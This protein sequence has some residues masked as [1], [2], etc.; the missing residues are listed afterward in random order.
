[1]E[2]SA[3]TKPDTDALKR[4]MLDIASEL[5]VPV[6][7]N[8]IVERLA[9]QPHVA[10]ARIWLQMPADICHTCRHRLTCH[11]AAVCLHLSATFGYSI[12]GRQEEWTKPERSP[13]FRLPM[14]QNRVGR[15]AQTKQPLDIPD[16][17]LAEALPQDSFAI[18]KIIRFS[19]QPMLYRGDLVGVLG[20]F[21]RMRP[22]PEMFT[23]LRMI[24]DQAA[25]A[26]ANARAFHEIEEL[27]AQLEQENAYLHE[28]LNEVHEAGEI[29]G[30]SPAI[31]NILRQIELVAPT[32]ASVLILGSRAQ[33]KSWWLG[34]STKE[35]RAGTG[36]WSR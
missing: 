15:I 34:R 23:W 21:T 26:V 16:T 5:S 11:D 33:A 20:V 22:N 10:L 4:L 7:M 36:P 32:E 3:S 2:F 14:G 27:K 24:A 12:A 8:T 13:F 9:A 17:S 31:F 1:M 30:Q 35:A 19:G 28:E 18:E 29:V 6:L 25:I